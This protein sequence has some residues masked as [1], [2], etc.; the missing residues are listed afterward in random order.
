VAANALRSADSVRV[1]ASMAGRIVRD[2]Q[3]GGPQPRFLATRLY[4]DTGQRV[5][6]MLDESWDLDGQGFCANF[7]RT[8]CTEFRYDSGRARYLM[9]SRRVDVPPSDPAFLDPVEDAVWTDYDGDEPYG[10]FQFFTNP[11]AT[12]EKTAYVAGLGSA[13]KAL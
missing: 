13:S 2:R 6:L 1:G 12:V 3:A 4:Y 8:R 10:D 5:W 7:Q 9:R 11:P